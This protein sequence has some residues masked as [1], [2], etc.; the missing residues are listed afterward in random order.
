MTSKQRSQWMALSIV[1]GFIYYARELPLEQKSF[2]AFERINN[3]CAKMKESIGTVVLDR[4]VKHLLNKQEKVQALLKSHG[5]DVYVMSYI[6]AIML[7]VNVMQDNIGNVAV[8]RHWAK[9]ESMLFTLYTHL[10]EV[11]TVGD[12]EDANEFGKD[13]VLA[14][15]A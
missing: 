5:E 14:V 10:E 2:K 4:D 11:D 1:E 9:L 3:Q 6:N 12:I 13:L 15:M 7:M 8:R